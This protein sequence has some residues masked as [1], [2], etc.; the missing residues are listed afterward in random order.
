MAIAGALAQAGWAVAAVDLP[1]HGITDTTSPLYQATE[2]TDLQSRSGRQC[3]WCIRTRRRDRSDRH[4][5][6]QSQLSTGEPR[7][8]APGRGQSA[9]ADARAA[10][11]WTSTANAAT[12]D[13]D[14]SRI[15]FV[16]QSLGPSWASVTA[17]RHH[18][19]IH[20][21]T[22]ACRHGVFGARRRSGDAAA[23]LADVRT[24]HQ[25][26]PE[27]QGLLPGTSLYAQYFRDV[28]NIVDAGDPLN[29]VTPRPRQ[30]SIYFQ[31]MVGATAPRR[32]CPTR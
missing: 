1:L 20:G 19:D 14:A 28:Q 12:V 26:G 24:A 18:R 15:A 5:F 17:R 30:R 21:D 8:P 11:A 22:C 13:I 4:A 10:N 9:G 16:G 7:Q 29:F 32:R 3:Q 27:A 6:H 25:R 2:R 23:R 31:Q